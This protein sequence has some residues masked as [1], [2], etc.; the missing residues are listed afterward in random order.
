MN[1]VDSVRV[2]IHVTQELTDVL[3]RGPLHVG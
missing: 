3:I 2:R 1:L